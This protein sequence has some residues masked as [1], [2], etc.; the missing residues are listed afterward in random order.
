MRLD[1]AIDNLPEGS[2]A[3]ASLTPVLDLMRRVVDEGR[4]AVSGLRS[5]ANV[6]PD[7]PH[8][9]SRMRDE[10]ALPDDV[11]FRVVVEGVQRPLNPMIR[12]DAYR[13]CREALVN[14][15]RHSRAKS[16]EI[17]FFYTR[18]HLRIL[19]RDDG[20]GIDPHVVQ[21]GRVGHWG[22][23]GM[24]ERA[25][26][27][28]GK[29]HVRSGPSAGTEVELSLPSHVA[30]EPEPANRFEKWLAKWNRRTK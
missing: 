8:A 12:D 16:I 30:F 26:R 15:V 28:G 29:L 25:E 22:L 7:L 19:V 18:K 20:C 13:I 2:T 9:L 6:G 17:D 14:T 21:S 1:V 3:K 5:G 4:N 23:P 27:I 10:L 24:R 11:E